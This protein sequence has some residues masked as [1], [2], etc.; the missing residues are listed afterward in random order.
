[1]AAR[2]IS[3]LSALLMLCL[4]TFW[5]SSFVVVKITLL[6]GLTPISIATFRFLL[7]GAMFLAA[8]LVNRRVNRDYA[9]RVENKDLPKLLLLALTGVTFFFTI[10]YTGIQMA[11]ASMAAIL[12]CLLSPILITV[13]SARMLR[14]HL[15]RRQVFGIGIAAAGTFTVIAGSSL[16]LESNTSFFAGTLILLSTPLLWATYT[17]VGKKMMQKYSP[18]LVSAYVNILGGLCLLP[19]ATAENSISRITTMSLQGWS[20]I[21]YL[22]FTCSLLG[23][24]IWL[25]VANQ[26]KGAVVSSFM[27]AEPLIT[28]MLATKFAGETVTL[29]TAAGGFLIFIG[30][31]FVSRN[32]TVLNRSPAVQGFSSG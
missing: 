7:A 26:V 3:P 11:S 5:G 18:F 23:Y 16:S 19:F 8:L 32:Q 1:M 10:Q 6:E 14:E 21:L 17:V 15:A 4:I 30:V 20:A 29:F 31:Y 12:V 27:F 25:H 13:F 9:L 22:A 28:V 24:S 2:T